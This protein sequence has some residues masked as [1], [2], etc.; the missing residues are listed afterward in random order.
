LIVPA[1]RVSGK[2]QPRG[3]Y[4]KEKISGTNSGSILFDTEPD[5]IK[6]T[7]V[8]TENQRE[9]NFLPA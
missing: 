7:D 8:S 9:G 3:K 1:E 6:T 5:T 2:L 4:G